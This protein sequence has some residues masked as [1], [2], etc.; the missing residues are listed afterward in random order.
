MKIN[1][2]NTLL[3]D[4]IKTKEKNREYKRKDLINIYIKY[5]NIIRDIYKEKREKYLEEAKK[6]KT[7]DIST[8]KG[9][10]KIKE[11]VI[12]LLNNHLILTD[13]GLLSFYY[14]KYNVYNA[15][16]FK[17]EI[18][19]EHIYIK[20]YNLRNIEKRN[21]E[22]N[23]ILK[24]DYDITYKIKEFIPKDSIKYLYFKKR[25]EYEKQLYENNGLLEDKI[26]TNKDWN[27]GIVNK[28]LQ[29]KKTLDTY[30]IYYLFYDYIDN[31]YHSYKEKLEHCKS[32]EN[33][34]LLKQETKEKLQQQEI[35]LIKKDYIDTEYILKVMFSK[36]N[37]NSFFNGTYT[38]E[39]LY[40]YFFDKDNNYKL[41]YSG[42][43]LIIYDKQRLFEVNKNKYKNKSLQK[44]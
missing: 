35:Y 3:F 31:I 36:Y 4:M 11:E 34:E 25:A 27:E 26:Y 44:K 13:N 19:T 29:C 14:S 8:D 40:F 39:N 30:Q 15:N 23:F 37:I 2:I 1:N 20:E 12:S 18:N 22:V 10:I 42:K 17:E 7:F 33:Q 41:G 6:S 32:K 38:D 16:F 24:E 43:W 5:V 21:I 28:Y 9:L